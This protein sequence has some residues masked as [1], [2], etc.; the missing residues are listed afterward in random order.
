MKRAPYLFTLFLL[1]AAC[2]FGEAPI[3]EP[4]DSSGY[5][6]ELRT[7]PSLTVDINGIRE[8]AVLGS[9]QWTYPSS[10]GGTVIEH[11]SGPQPPALIEG[12]SPA[13]VPADAEIEFSF[14][15]EP[16]DYEV[17]I[18]REGGTGSP[19]PEEMS[20]QG[21]NGLT[22]FNV[23]AEWKEG[24]ANYAFALDILPAEGG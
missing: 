11:A 18:W 24:E 4:D 13:S 17:E 1:L 21:L 20:L 22:V 2:S 19:F 15:Q 8:N 16:I 3:T 9:Y 6:S 14:G 12:A 10:D 5:A 23:I 7:P